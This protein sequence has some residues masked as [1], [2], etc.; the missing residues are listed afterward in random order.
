MTVNCDSEAG[1]TQ[2]SEAAAAADVTINLQIDID[3][4]MHRGGVPMDDPAAIERLALAIR[5]LPS[6]EFDGLTTHRGIWYEGA[7]G[8]ADAGHEEGQLLVDIAEKLS[9][10]G[11]EV[12]EITAGGTFTGKWA[13]EVPGVTESR[14]GTYVFY[15]LMHVSAGTATWD[16][17]ALTALCSV[18]SHREGDRLTID[19]GSKTFSGDRGVIGGSK[20]AIPDVA[21]AAGRKVF[22]DRL[23]EEHGMARAEEDVELGDKI[24]FYPFHACTCCNLTNEIVGVRGDRVEVVWPVLARGL[25]Q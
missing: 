20:F 16:Q 6:V 25:R 17:L 13:A 12:R 3:S 22:V 8:P 10:S 21:V 24:R 5:W 19:G 18:V 23:T 4:G 1:A 15:D 11:I 9:A 7:P 2:A 14:A